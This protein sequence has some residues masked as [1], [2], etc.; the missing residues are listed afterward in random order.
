VQKLHHNEPVLDWLDSGIHLTL[1]DGDKAYFCACLRD[2]NMKRGVTSTDKSMN[3]FDAY[4]ALEI[5]QQLTLFQHEMYMALHQREVLAWVTSKKK[6]ND[7]PI[8]HA[9]VSHFNRIASWA[10]MGIVIRLRKTERV[11]LMN[12]FIEVCRHC[13]RLNNYMSLQA[14]LSALN[15]SSVVR[16]KETI[17]GVGVSAMRELESYSKLMSQLGNFSAYRQHYASVRPPSIPYIGYVF[18][19][20]E[21]EK[22]EEKNYFLTLISYTNL[23]QLRIKGFVVFV[24]RQSRLF[25][26][27]RKC[28]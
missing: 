11:R 17:E 10:V 28:I 4:S 16:L 20:E 2:V 6:V 15:H 18:L 14:I 13:L 19:N 1:T 12:K 24:G 21:G 26:W 22:K 9:L 25:W 3:I 23:L 27:E 5:A 7:C 8:F